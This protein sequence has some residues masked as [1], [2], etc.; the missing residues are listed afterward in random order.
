MKRINRSVVVLW[1]I[2]GTLL[3]TGGAGVPA[4][5]DSFRDIFGIEIQFDRLK[6]SGLT[7][8]QII[9]S[10]ITKFTDLESEEA[11]AQIPRLINQYLAGLELRVNSSNTF[12][13]DRVS[14]KI[15]YLKSYF[16][17]M[18]HW[19]VT[20]NVYEGAK[21]KLE[22]AGLGYLFEDSQLFC[23][24]SL[25]PRSEIVNRAL[26][27]CRKE[28]Q[29]AIV[30]GDTIHDLEAASF[31]GIPVLLIENRQTKDTLN[32]FTKYRKSNVVSENWSVNEFHSK[33][34]ELI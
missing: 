10:L 31:C 28:G 9:Y 13:L 34:Y 6:H 2:D 20:G 23:C 17:F 3:S 15:D 14:A 16:P 26:Q 18:E 27:N 22:A 29:N 11:E 7:D 25:G 24:N 32:V 12:Q 8:F 5:T 1:D 30:V 19:I 4:L 21:I 33:L